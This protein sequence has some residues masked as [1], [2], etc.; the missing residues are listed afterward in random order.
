MEE[1]HALYLKAKKRMK[2]G[3]F[4]LRKW[5]TSDSALAQKFAAEDGQNAKTQSNVERAEETYAKTTL[6]NHVQDKS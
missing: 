6:G 4:S 2:E 3:G 1:A 5:K